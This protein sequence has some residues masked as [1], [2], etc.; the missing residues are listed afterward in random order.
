V[1]SDRQSQELLALELALDRLG[2]MN[3]RQRQPLCRA[4]I[5]FR[6]AFPMKVNG[7]SAPKFP[8]SVRV[9]SIFRKGESCFSG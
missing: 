6:P 7:I 2:R 3:P 5:G 9:P 8:C 1:L 4:L